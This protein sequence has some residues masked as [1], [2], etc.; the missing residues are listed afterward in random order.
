MIML[1]RR[2]ST[3]LR[4]RQFGQMFYEFMLIFLAVM[5]GFAAENWRENL[6]DRKRLKEYL[7]SIRN[8]LQADQR[9]ME[10]VLTRGI[11]AQGDI[12]FIAEQLYGKSNDS[13]LV[14]LYMKARGLGYTVPSV[15]LQ[16]QAYSQMKSAGDLRLIGNKA[17]SDTLGLL[18]VIYKDETET[19]NKFRLEHCIRYEGALEGVFDAS[20]FLKLSSG[21]RDTGILLKAIRQLKK[22]LNTQ[23]IPILLHRM[24]VLNTMTSNYIL[25]AQGAKTGF[26]RVEALLTAELK[27]LE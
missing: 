6:E 25:R 18:Y 23:G 4:K 27:K 16:D 14:E 12:K 22:P 17:L 13:L 20:I 19:Q 15:R 7:T 2:I 10:R 21:E 3:A 24:H 9:A 26:Q 11:R 5:A 8:D 1:F